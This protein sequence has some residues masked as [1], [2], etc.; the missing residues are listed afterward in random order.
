MVRA[1]RNHENSVTV[2][3]YC[4]VIGCVQN[5][6]IGLAKP[7]ASLLDFGLNALKCP[8]FIVGL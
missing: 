7:V 2:L 1:H 8:T 3:R 6:C 5:S 4:S